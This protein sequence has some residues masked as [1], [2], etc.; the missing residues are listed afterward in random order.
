[1]TSE[2]VLS[3]DWRAKGIALFAGRLL[4]RPRTLSDESYLGY[5][6]RVA[7][8]NGLS[9]PG[10]LDCIDINLPKAHGMVRW[11]PHCFAEDDCYW[12]ESWYTG[13]AA[14]FKHRCWLASI[15][16][17]C[18][19]MLRWNRARFA[20]CACG[21]LLRDAPATTFS[22]ELQDLID[23][24]LD[25]SAERL[26]RDERWHI[27]RFLGA[28]YEF[29]LRGKPL[30]K[31]SRQREN[32]EQTLVT[33]GASL[34]ADGSACFELFDRL[35]VPQTSEGNVPLLSEVFPR[36]LTMLRT[37]LN[38]GERQWMV[39]VLNEYVAHSAQRGSPVIW[40]RKGAGERRARRQ[41]DQQ[42]ARNPAV[43]TM[44]KRTSS[45][46]P[47]RQTRSGRRKFVI[48]SA[49]LQ[50]IRDALRSQVRPKTAARYSGMSVA[51]IRALVSAGLIPS[52]EGRINLRSMDRL[53]SNI[54]ASCAGNI[55]ALD[56]PIC[57]AEAL[58]LYVPVSGSAAF[59]TGLIEK[60]AW[61]A[62][63]PGTTPALRSIFIDRRRVSCIARG[64]AETGASISVV[65][66]AHMLGV[67]QEVM[68]HLV[69]K[70]LLKT[71]AGKL[72]RRTARVVDVGDLRNF[73][74]QFRPLIA[75]ANEAGICARDAPNW[76]RQL[77]IEIV[78]G[79]LVDG[80]RQYWI[81]RPACVGSSHGPR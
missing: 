65:A 4:V 67:K 8:A 52:V 15:C 10:W 19:R 57:L 28:L 36:L 38:E 80:G 79:P 7:F 71:R 51:R 75:A 50:C 34:L 64:P 72:G 78:T 60:G 73:T 70:G 33:V 61:L 21:A 13:P 16:C 11:C 12:R 55:A 46:V 30:K 59:F 49:E 62:S 58:R 22:A 26:V 3:L 68:Y 39:D 37:Q 81:R 23:E 14:C 29:G 63:E 32:V 9:N 41:S 31:A 42:R 53:L 1:M 24:R 56:D 17:G 35:R 44:L 2:Q 48:C 27:A 69:N 54:A 6:L 18:R 76:A 74:E 43:M 47:V 5:R 40:E 77:G 25:T 45:K 20:A 66:A